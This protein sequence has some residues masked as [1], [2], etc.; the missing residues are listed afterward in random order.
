VVAFAPER[1]L[2]VKAMSVSVAVVA[3]VLALVD[4]HASPTVTSVAR[5]ALAVVPAL[6][7]VASC[8][9]I[10]SSESFSTFINIGASWA[11][12]ARVAVALETSTSVAA[13]GVGTAIVQFFPTLINVSANNTISCIA[14]VA[15]AIEPTIAVV[16]FG[17]EIAIMISSFTFVH[18]VATNAIAR[19]SALAFTHERSWRIG[20]NGSWTIAIREFHRA[21]VNIFA[22][23]TIARIA[24]FALTEKRSNCVVA[25]GRSSAVVG[26][27]IAFIVVRAGGTITGESWVAGANIVVANEC[28][29]RG[30]RR[31]HRGV[32]THAN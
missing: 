20:A 30:I 7:V 9:M 6:L 12:K 11:S 23:P 29:A 1:T 14:G 13:I 17:S 10:A 4:I 3:A 27:I 32:D 5:N 18:I 31:A 15:S 16:A 2:V 28:D 21:F 19:V 24:R 22:S 25:I 8:E 26:A